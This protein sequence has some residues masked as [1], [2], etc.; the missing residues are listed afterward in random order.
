MPP[1]RAPGVSSPLRDRLLLAAFCA[2]VWLPGLPARTLWPTD[3]ARY[4]V[5]ARDMA[6]TGDY[7]VPMKRGDVYHSQPP[8]FLWSG[9]AAIHM[10]GGASEWGLRIPSF[11]A[12][13]CGVLVV[14][15]LATA[16]FGAAAGLLAAL[17]LATDV[18]YLIQAQWI[19]TD[20]LLCFLMTAALAC[21]AEGYRNRRRGWYLACYALVSAATL[22]KGP[23]GV[24]L[25][26]LVILSFLTVQRDWKEI[27]RMRLPAAALI[28][29][30]MVLPWYLMFGART[31]GDQAS[32][33]VMTQSVHRFLNAW[34]NQQPWHYF[35]RQLPVDILPWS[36]A[37]PFALWFGWRRMSSLPWRFLACWM[38]V[39]FLFFS[40]STG[41]RGVYLL[42]LHPAAAMAIGWFWD[43]GIRAAGDDPLARAARLAG[44]LTAGLFMAAAAVAAGWMALGP[45]APGARQAAWGLAA[46]AGIAGLALMLLPLRRL[47]YAAATATGALCLAALA[48]AAPI[49]NRRLDAV[50]FARDVSARVPAGAPLAMSRRRFEEL[51]WYGGLAPDRELRSGHGDLSEWLASPGTVYAVV[52]RASYE[53]LP[54]SLPSSWQEIAHGLVAGEPYHLI[55][56]QPQMAGG[57]NR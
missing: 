57:W 25:P 33:L 6:A 18:R 44:R 36:L 47:P 11:V 10:T 14:H 52:D 8:L 49:Q 43:A 16:W 28:F 23:V 41:K 13:L 5:I 46:I 21:F 53:Q 2:M 19:S 9:V 38:S 24:V 15:A 32:D 3:E 12:G 35:L 27:L 40:V 31:A 1:P 4:A 48:L 45:L 55:V 20:M 39:M 7:V 29:A 54:S 51:A 26:G 30:A 50:A 22:T 42:P 17:V 37:F 34:N 56:N